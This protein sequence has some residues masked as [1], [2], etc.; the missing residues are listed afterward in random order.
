MQSTVRGCTLA[1][2]IGTQMR[3]RSKDVAHAMMLAF[4]RG[5]GH[6]DR[7]YARE[8]HTRQRHVGCR[9]EPRQHS[10]ESLGVLAVDVH[11][12]QLGHGGGCAPEN[13]KASQGKSR[14]SKP[15][16]AVECH[17]VGA[18]LPYDARVGGV[19]LRHK[20]G[21]HHGACPGSAER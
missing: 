2:R 4:A 18:Q 6:D 19:I 5:H 11:P 12:R 7:L 14:V 17:V 21:H 8:R 1:L 16:N 15:R 20:L 13:P 10:R 9:R 3:M